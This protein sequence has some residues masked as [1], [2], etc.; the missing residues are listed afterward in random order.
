[1]YGYPI[2]ACNAIEWSD[3]F[4]KFLWP[5]C[6]YVVWHYS[7]ENGFD[8]SSCEIFYEFFLESK[9]IGKSFIAWD[10]TYQANLPAE[11]G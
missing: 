1:M 3:Y 2:H 6:L 5:E 9:I 4:A 8:Q 10:D 11:M 7:K